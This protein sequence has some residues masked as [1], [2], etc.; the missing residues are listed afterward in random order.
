MNLSHSPIWTELDQAYRGVHQYGGHAFRLKPSAL[1]TDTLVCEDT[2]S[3]VA[4][5]CPLTSTDAADLLC[6]M[7]DEFVEAHSCRI[8]VD[9]M[10]R[11]DWQAWIEA[12]LGTFD[13]SV[14][15]RVFPTNRSAGREF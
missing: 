13:R 4:A 6:R 12:E 10:E 11:L 14:F 8:E 3:G 9:G 7:L 15:V 1:L 5:G 2:N